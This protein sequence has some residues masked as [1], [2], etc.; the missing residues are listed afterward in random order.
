MQEM[1]SSKAPEFFP[2][3]GDGKLGFGMMRLPS[4]GEEIDIETVKRMVDSY[5]QSGF[6][7]FDTAHGYHSGKSELAVRQ[8][9]TER[10]ERGSFV[11]TNK[12]S[13]GFIEKDSDVLPLFEEQLKACGT[14]Y[15][16]FYLLHA[17]SSGNYR[18]FTDCRAFE[19]LGELKKQGKIRHMGCSFHD[20]AEFLDKVLT[21]HPELEVVQLQ[22]N[23]LDWEDKNV[24]SRQCY[25]VCVKH[26]KPVIVM[27]PVKGGSLA[28]LDSEA[29]AILDSVRKDGDSNASFALRFAAGPENVMMVLSGMSSPEQM[30]DNISNLK[31]P[32]PLDKDEA[33]ALERIRGHYAALPL[34]PCTGCRYCVDGCPANIRIP[35]T[36]RFLNRQTMFP[37]P[38]RV[39]HEMRWLTEDHGA[40]EDC[41]NCSQCSDVCPQHIDIP[42]LMKK[43]AEYRAG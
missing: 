7:Y 12:L 16:D 32:R 33:D 21:E 35:E 17:V 8:A 18:K 38:S 19:I 1:K 15:F 26:N 31:E 39:S 23:Y 40:P 6:R 27:E 24:Q 11:L 20:S 10:Y 42:A 28:S 4:K 29:N 9:V 22:L 13:G 34:I 14:E 36:L 41:L 43:A 5:M 3:V 37:D 25:E 2:E 30:A